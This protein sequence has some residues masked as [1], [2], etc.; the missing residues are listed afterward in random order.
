M[1][2]DSIPLIDLSQRHDERER[3]SLAH[4][5]SAV[6]HEV[7][8]LVVTNHGIDPE[9][10]D[11]VFDLMERFFSLNEGDKRL[12]DKVTSPQFRGW[13]SWV[14]THQ[15]SHRCSRADRSVDRMARC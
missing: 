12:I 8:F 14:G 4:R 3:T 10:I 7:G 2:F 13:E 6:C 1:S 9:L 11:D 5:L 15:Q